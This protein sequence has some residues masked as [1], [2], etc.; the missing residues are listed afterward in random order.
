VGAYLDDRD[1][2][3]AE[4]LVGGRFKLTALLQRRVQEIIRNLDRTQVP[5]ESKNPI[6]QALEEIL[7]GRIELIADEETPTL[8]PEATTTVFP[9]LPER[10]LLGDDPLSIAGSFAASETPRLPELPDPQPA[11]GDDDASAEK[12]EPES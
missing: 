4:K 1:L 8:E 7:D 11:S 6:E 9:E 12:N 2:D 10:K 3:R 5:L